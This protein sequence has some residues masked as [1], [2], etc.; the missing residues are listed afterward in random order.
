MTPERLAEIRAA[1]DS[2]DVFD[3]YDLMH[4]IRELLAALDAEKAETERLMSAT[5]GESDA[6]KVS[7]ALTRAQEAE[8][9]LK[10]CLDL[11]RGAYDCARTRCR[12]EACCVPEE[13]EARLV[14]ISE[15]VK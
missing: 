3:P 1:A 13:V 4:C 11:A 6:I 12:S 7:L 15:L 9:D 14:A 10:R 2:G 5:I 8:G